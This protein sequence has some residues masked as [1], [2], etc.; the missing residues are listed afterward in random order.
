[1]QSQMTSELKSNFKKQT[2]K[3]QMEMLMA[4]LQFSNSADD[5]VSYEEVQKAAL[6]L[7]MSVP[8]RDQIDTHMKIFFKMLPT[9][10]QQREGFNYCNFNFDENCMQKILQKSAHVS[11]DLNN[12]TTNEPP[13][14]NKRLRGEKSDFCLPPSV[15]NSVKKFHDT[16]RGQQPS[17]LTTKLKQ[18]EQDKT[19]MTMLKKEIQIL[20]TQCEL[21]QNSND[22]L[23]DLATLQKNYISILEH[24][25]TNLND[26]LERNLL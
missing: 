25:V 8:T 15:L 10:K 26:I 13:S 16:Q 2:Y 11:N 21:D 7:G 4:D 3:I 17:A 5:F 24:R 20:S 9:K 18:D 22:K 6:T 1:M 12:A 19:N 23:V 14:G